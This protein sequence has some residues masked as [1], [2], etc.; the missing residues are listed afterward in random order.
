MIWVYYIFV[1]INL[2][3][4]LTKKQKF[5]F[6]DLYYISSLFYYLNAFF[7]EIYSL[8]SLRFPI[9]LEINNTTYILLW[10]NQIIILMFYVIP[11]RYNKNLIYEEPKMNYNLVSSYKIVVLFLFIAA[12]FFTIDMNLFTRV[13][14]NK[15]ELLQDSSF[16]ETYFKYG[17][18]Y[19]FVSGLYLWKEL[20]SVWK[21]L[22]I[23]PLIVT[24]LMGH[25][26]FIV[27]SLI[28]FFIIYIN[29]NINKNNLITFLKKNRKIIIA[30]LFLISFV[31]IIKGVSGALFV[32]DTELVKERLSSPSYYFDSFKM[33]ESN[34][35]L[36][37]I[38]YVVSYGLDIS[39]STYTGILSLL[40]PFIGR[41]F[42]IESFNSFLQASFY[43]E[44]NPGTLGNSFIAEAYAQGSIILVVFLI[45][46]LLTFANVFFK[47]T[48]SPKT[49]LFLRT[50]A[51][52]VGIEC[53]FYIHRNSL[54][55]FFVRLR[56]YLYL[57][58]LF[59]LIY[60]C[61]NIF[62][63]TLTKRR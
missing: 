38:N 54:Y 26:S 62:K 22:A 49:S 52:T 31:Y 45:I 57:T 25:R 19:F 35:I 29:K 56:V 2:F 61:Y 6:V 32:G 33:S 47:L 11:R 43:P 42:Q 9:P 37:H 30:A 7:G 8:H 40:I 39:K 50:W 1:L 44:Y 48:V 21:V 53:A 10:L 4:L 46:I 23:Y 15:S 41:F 63:Q 51:M 5:T 14:F 13:E 18:F 3:I 28:A 36:N 17:S 58:I 34:I 12:L 20:N 60:T 16:I 24:F 55:T 27:L 59:Y